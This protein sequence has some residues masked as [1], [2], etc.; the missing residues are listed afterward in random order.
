MKQLQ[1]FIA[2]LLGVVLLGSCLDPNKDIKYNK[3]TKADTEAFNF[4]KTTYE[5]ALFQQHAAKNYNLGAE[6]QKIAQEYQA[7]SEELIELATKNN[8]LMPNFS[9]THFDEKAAPSITSFAVMAD[10][11]VSDSAAIAS[12]AVIQEESHPV[13]QETPAQKVIHS[14][15]EI[16][17]QFEVVTR[18]TNVSIRNFAASKLEGLKELL[19]QTKSSI[20]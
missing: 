11:A 9:A 18:N 5:E 14:Q 4:L 15:E 6:S 12:P 1:L 13:A 8:V 10:T 19:E 20:K 16:V 3:Y 2:L 17:H 7:L